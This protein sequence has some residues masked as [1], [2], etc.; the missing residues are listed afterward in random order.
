MSNTRD[1]SRTHSQ[2]KDPPVTSQFAE[3]RGQLAQ[4][5]QR[6]SEL[7]DLKTIVNSLNEQNEAKDRKS[8]HLQQ[9]VEDLEQYTRQDDIII[10]GPVFTKIL[11]L[12]IN[13]ILRIF[14]RIVIFLIHLHVYMLLFTKLL[15]LEFSKNFVQ[16]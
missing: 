14:L 12:R 13:L 11:I 5:N 3:I 9:R 2:T 6:Q 10:S 1:G 4:I 7:G 16:I 8:A 15:F